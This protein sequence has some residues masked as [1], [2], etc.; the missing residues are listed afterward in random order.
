[1]STLLGARFGKYEEL[2]SANSSFVGLMSSPGSELVEYF[3]LS[4]AGRAEVTRR[5]ASS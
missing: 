5:V 3:A 2:K 4:S 1:M